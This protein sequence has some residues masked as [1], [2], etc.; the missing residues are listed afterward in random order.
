MSK[1]LEI[2]ECEYELN[3]LKKRLEDVRNM[4]KI[5]SRITYMKSWK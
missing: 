4:K 1:A 5:C 2:Y 3:V